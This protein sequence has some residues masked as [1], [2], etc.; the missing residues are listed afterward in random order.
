[1]LEYLTREQI[2]QVDCA[3]AK[4]CPG[5]SEHSSIGM[6]KT[7]ILS[8]AS[9]MNQN[10]SSRYLV[11]PSFLNK[12]ETD[13]LLARSKQLLDEFSLS[14]HPLVCIGRYT[15]HGAKQSLEDEIHYWR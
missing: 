9:Q 10:C 7:P 1:M 5:L 11:I 4:F 6:G 2:D 13:A 14:D 8:T 15:V 3:A 12:T